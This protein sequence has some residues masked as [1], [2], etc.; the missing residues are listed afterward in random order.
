M[1]ARVAVYSSNGLTYKGILPTIGLQFS[2]EVGGGGTCTFEALMSDIDALSAWDAVIKIQLETTPGTWVNGPAYATRHNYTHPGGY[3]RFRF[4]AKALLEAWGEDA[5]LFPE[6]AVAKIP[7]RARTE[8]GIG[9]MSSAYDPARDPDESWD[10]CYETGRTAKPD[11]WPSG[12]GAEWISASGATDETE[13]KYFRTWLTITGSQPRLLEFFM[14]SDES[15]TLWIAGERVIQTSSV[16]TGKKEFSKNK[17]VLYPGTYAVGVYTATHFSKG[18]DGID[19]ILVAGAILDSEG[20]PTSWILKSNNSTWKACRRD[21]EPPNDVPPGPTPGAVLRYLVAEAAERNCSGWPNVTLGFSDTHDSNGL[22]WDDIS[23]RMFRYGSDSYWAIFQ[24]FSE[25]DEVDIWMGADLV[26]R[27]A[28]RQG[29]ARSIVFT[30]EHF[31]SFATRGTPGAGSW[32]MAL[33]HDGWTYA[34]VSGPRREYALELGQ[35]LTR[36]VGKK[37]IKASLRDKWRWD[38]SGSMNPP[39]AGWRPYVDFG[40]GDW[41]TVDYQAI[42]HNLSVVSISATAGEGGLLFDIEF[43]EYPNDTTSTLFTQPPERPRLAL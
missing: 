40:V 23:E 15:A 6:Y 11:Y 42:E 1:R 4:T 13:A 37:I 38:A 19:P 8:R 20:D 34:S 33:C 39:Q 25:S 10:A 17:I 7:R 27:A 24:A 30:A 18:G 5:V 26:L 29:Q 14:S 16:E 21:D 41:M 32:A 3:R 28:A 36:V 31:H 12:T 35:A 9:W 2:D 43:T 22:P